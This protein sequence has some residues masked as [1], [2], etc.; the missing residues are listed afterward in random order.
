MGCFTCRDLWRTGRLS[1]V[2]FR[3]H[4]E[5]CKILGCPQ[6]SR[7]ICNHCIV[8]IHE[9]QLLRSF[10]IRCMKSRMNLLE[11]PLAVPRGYVVHTNICDLTIPTGF[12]PLVV[13]DSISGYINRHRSQRFFQALREAVV[14]RGGGF[15]FW[16][17]RTSAAK[18][19]SGHVHHTAFALEVKLWENFHLHSLRLTTG[20]PLARFHHLPKETLTG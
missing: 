17:R 6:R 4:G 7:N 13:S 18:L 5:P 14:L 12:E 3:L 1:M 20:G 8:L 9:S 2:I 16:S 11:K 19:A 15:P 10:P